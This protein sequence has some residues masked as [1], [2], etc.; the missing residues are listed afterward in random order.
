MTSGFKGIGRPAPDLTGVV[1]GRL[2]ALEYLSPDEGVKLFP[3][4]GERI[5]TFQ[6]LLLRGWS[7]EHLQH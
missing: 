4:R 2:C 1:F 5:D 7:I 3:D 6:L